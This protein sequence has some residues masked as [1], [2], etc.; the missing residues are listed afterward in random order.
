[1]LATVF[2]LLILASIPGYAQNP[3]IAEKIEEMLNKAGKPVDRDTHQAALKAFGK[4]Q[5]AMKEQLTLA[6]V[7]AKNQA[8]IALDDLERERKVLSLSASLDSFLGILAP[9]ALGS[10]ALADVE[11]L[12]VDKQVGAPLATPGNTTL[13]SRGSVPTVLGFAV[14]N[15]AIT[16]TQEGTSFTFRGNASGFFDLFRGQGWLETS[17]QAEPLD[18]FLRRVSF[19]ISFD[20]TREIAEGAETPPELRFTGSTR[21][22][23]A[24]SFRFHLINQRD[25]RRTTLSKL[26]SGFSKE[27]GDELARRLDAVFGPVLATQQFK[28]IQDRYFPDLYYRPNAELEAPFRRYVDEVFALAQATLPDLDERLRLALRATSAYE[29]KRN[30]ILEEINRMPT[31]AVE[32]LANRP[33]T[34]SA[35]ST[36]NLVGEAAFL[37]GRGALT[38]NAGVTLF[39]DT[40]LLT[41]APP[42]AA[43]R[44]TPSQLRNWFLSGELSVGLAPTRTAVRTGQVVLSFAG[45]FERILNSAFYQQRLTEI[46]ASPATV[47]VALPGNLG[48]F[49]LKLEIPIPGTALR[50]PLSYS[51]A[52]RTELLL[53]KENRVQFGLTFDVDNIVNQLLK[54]PVLAR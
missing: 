53:E 30:Q 49:L 26:W 18:K 25:P 39:N 36:V 29:N 13:V 34:G 1:M 10:E 48:A 3:A 15:G 4:A 44:Q 19:S 47:P 45:K 12:R 37:K 21:Q 5:A 33:R 43:A 51:Y 32:Y 11:K 50:V 23:A 38:G 42:P 40:S 2:L 9:R 41:V 52:T 24:W 17:E 27:E 7:A 28:D 22:I 14:E 31:L 46:G 20:P 35:L 6:T 8:Q 16:N 54:T